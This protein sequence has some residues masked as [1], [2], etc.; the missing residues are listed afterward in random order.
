M[1]RDAQVKM[2]EGLAP[3]DITNAVFD[4]GHLVDA[5]GIQ[6]DW[7]RVLITFLKNGEP[8]RGGALR[9]LWRDFE[10]M[11]VPH[12]EAVWAYLHGRKKARIGPAATIGM[13]RLR[14]IRR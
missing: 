11:V 8:V 5:L 1:Q 3:F 9:T 6:V 4:L 14:L 12:F 7:Y 10:P 2:Q 13:I